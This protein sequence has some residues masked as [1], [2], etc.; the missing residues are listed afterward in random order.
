MSTT[1]ATIESG[2]EL[3]HHRTIFDGWRSISI[4]LYMALLGYG[5]SVGLPVISSAWVELLGFTEVEVGRVAGAD[6][7]GLSIG[8]VLTSLLIKYLNR[9]LLVL[10]GIVLAVTANGLC[11]V[12]LEY[13]V[14]LWLRLLAGIGSGIYTAIAIVTLGAT[15]KP[16]R[17][18]T[19]LLFA[20]AF[21][22]ALEMQVLPQL[23]MNGIYGVFITM[24]LI[25]LLFL[26]WVP[27]RAA[28]KTLD[29]ELDVTDKQGIHHHIYQH[30]P[31]YAP[32]LS[33]TAIF[34][35]Y[36]C[37]GAYWTYIELANLKAGVDDAWINTALVWGSFMSILG[38]LFATFIS[39]RIGMARPLMVALLSM[40][41]VVS[42]MIGGVSN[43]GLFIMICLFNFLWFF[44]DVYQMGTISTLDPSGR[45]V[46]LVPGAQGV[47]QIVG[48][49][50][51]ATVLSYELGYDGV[52]FMCS[53][54][55]IISL[56]IYA[57][58]YIRLRRIIPAL[59][60]AS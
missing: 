50:L 10:F 16:A 41:I 54:A 38:C 30:I 56:I 48:P 26:H 53:V 3:E 58:M 1:N 39:N 32:W 18:F 9:R 36:V 49:N 42:M 57:A 14:M 13:E 40:A 34:A 12:F 11:M 22:Q 45:Y 24:Y 59:A 29:V 46:S 31:N 23:S 55:A 33:L 21:T 35:I 6:L 37:I 19:W 2:V 27:P 17:A 4:A 25:S 43:I 51:A 7:G 8:A 44:I 47:G 52:F 28:G 60:D 20:F 15:C 5:V